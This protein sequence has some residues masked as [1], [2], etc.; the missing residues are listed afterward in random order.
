MTSEY[1]QAPKDN[2]TTSVMKDLKER[3]DRGFKKYETTLH[4]NN[5]QN[6]LQ[7]AYEE[8]LDFAQY[9]KKEISNLRNIQAL[10]NK[11]PNDV[12]LGEQVRRIYGKK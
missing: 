8:A 9:L 6:M 3:A 5:H 4:D 7:H 12:E 11:F 10:V 2:I 1:I